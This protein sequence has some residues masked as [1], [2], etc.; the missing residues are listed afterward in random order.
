MLHASLRTLVYVLPFLNLKH[1]PSQYR[2]T[3]FTQNQ[4]IV[5]ELGTPQDPIY[6]KNKN[7]KQNKKEKQNKTKQKTPYF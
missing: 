4:K 3:P 1:I 7:K 6:N 5:S 2:G